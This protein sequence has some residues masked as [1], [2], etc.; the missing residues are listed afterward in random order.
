M[1]NYRVL[2]NHYLKEDNQAQVWCYTD[3]KGREIGA[4]VTTYCIA[5]SVDESDWG[6]HST[7]AEAEDRARELAKKPWAFYTRALRNGLAY[8]ASGRDKYFATLEERDAAI[9]KYFKD[10]EKRAV[11]IK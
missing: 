1:T 11:K 7:F 5:Y 9:A 3:R 2:Q 6:S 10:A 4:R 8:G